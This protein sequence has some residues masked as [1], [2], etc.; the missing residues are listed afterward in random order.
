MKPLSGTTLGIIDEIY[1]E[2][3]TSGWI[4]S[5][6]K[7]LEK[8]LLKIEESGEVLA[9]RNLLPFVLNTNK[10]NALLTAQT[11]D[12]L[13]TQVPIT[14]LAQLD[15]QMRIF[16]DRTG[17]SHWQNV[18]LQQI[19]KLENFGDFT[20]SLLAVSSFHNSGF[21][22]EIAISALAKIGDGSELPYLLIRANDWVAN[23][24]AIAK[25]ALLS[26]IVSEYARYFVWNLPLILRLESCGRADHT[27]LIT[28]VQSLLQ[29]KENAK[30]LL[31]G[32]QSE[33]LTI[34]RASFG[35]AFQAPDTEINQQAIEIG[36]LDKDFLIRV[37]STRKINLLSESDKLEK[38]VSILK[39]DPFMPIRRLTLTNLVHT[40]PDRA[41]IELRQ[42]LLDNHASIRD[43]SRFYLR[44]MQPMDFPAF[45]RTILSEGKEGHIYSSISGLGE[46]GIAEDDILI[47]PFITHRFVKIRVASLRSLAKLNVHKHI[48]TFLKALEDESPKVSREA[49]RALSFSR[50][51]I[52]Y[53]DEIW[54]LVTHDSSPHVK[55]NALSLM[56]TLSKWDSLV[57]LLR[58][59]E[60]QEYF[61]RQYAQVHI[62]RWLSS[63][64]QSFTQ[65]TEKQIKEIRGI[66]NDIEA[67]LDKY[68]KSNLELIIR[69]FEE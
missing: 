13:L 8:L 68:S 30:F 19:S 45:Y 54:K 17:H 40:L 46:T 66:F 18:H 69:S 7:K 31:E 29:Q 55:E 53:N 65:P 5:N 48:T 20:T 22:R 9:I 41:I 64:N 57:Y 25:Q 49:A 4:F 44:K 11:I 37:W 58:A 36:I 15:E 26:R 12:K 63:Y 60:L 62:K 35:I 33:N 16:Y 34:R 23:V 2:F 27:E 3:S 1:D 14:E 21:I 52:Q 51:F 28:S 24:Q 42:A 50:A 47:S 6:R 43:L 59:V 32:C 61:V 39:N 56:A 67:T 10:A 38:A